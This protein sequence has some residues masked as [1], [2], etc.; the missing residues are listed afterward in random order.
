MAMEMELTPAQ[1]ACIDLEKYEDIR[2]LE[3]KAASN[4]VKIAELQQENEHIGE[5]LRDPEENHW[6]IRSLKFDY[7]DRNR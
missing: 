6:E 5:L 2:F 1:Q 7:E 4:A 3:W